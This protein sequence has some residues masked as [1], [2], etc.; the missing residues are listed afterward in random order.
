MELINTNKIRNKTRTIKT[1][2]IL[3]FSIS[4]LIFFDQILYLAHTISKFIGIPTTYITE[5]FLVIY[6][7]LIFYSLLSV[8]SN[9]KIKAFIVPVVL[10]ILYMLSMLIYGEYSRFLSANIAERM[11]LYALPSYIL[12][13]LVNDMNDV[14]QYFKYFCII[15]IITQTFSVLNDVFLP[16]YFVKTDYQGISYSLLIPTIYYLSKKYKKIHDYMIIAFLVFLLIVA[17]GRGAL[18]CMLL[19]ILYSGIKS[20]KRNLKRTLLTIMLLMFVLIYFDSIIENVVLF[21]EKY[22]FNG[23]ILKYYLMG[24]VL[25]LSGRDNIYSICIDIIKRFPLLGCGLGGDRYWLGIYGFK[26][27]NYPHNFFL[28]ILVQYGIIFGG[29]FLLYFL[30]RVIKCLSYKDMESSAYKLFNIM[31]FSYGFMGL[32]FS[33]SYLLNVSFFA[34]LPVMNKILKERKTNEKNRNIN[35]SQES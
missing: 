34:M 14:M 16:Q 15:S 30:T 27:G 20:V 17:G 23:S 35:I 7:V 26:Y 13:S 10:F 9:I 5:I 25:D 29:I 21:A 24:N 3:S 33:S 2:K 31:F 11:F 1:E 18:V 28:E 22:N 19:Y 32:M 8:R 4:F 6:L 12:M